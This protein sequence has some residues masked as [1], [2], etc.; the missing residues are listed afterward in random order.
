MGARLEGRIALVTGA[1][2]GIG[3]A[4][5]RLLAAEGARV[6]ATDIEPAG[7]AETAEGLDDA[8][9]TRRLD[10]TSEAE[11]RSAVD[12]TTAEF[13]GLHVLLNNAGIAPK[14]T[15][16]Q[17]SLEGW[18][19]IHGICL[20]GVYLGCHAALPAM[21]ASG[22]GSIVNISSVAALRGVAVYAAYCS[23]KAGVHMLTKTIALHCGR[24][25]YNIRANSVHPGPID[26]PI[27][28][29]DRERFGRRAIDA[30]AEAIPLGR[31][32]RPEEVAHCVLFLASEESSF[33]NGT[34]LVVDGGYCAK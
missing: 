1:G 31:I 17:E 3:R 24:R 12:A 9:L 34:E 18:R 23:A 27:L 21:A 19:R 10:V 16:E 25:G 13:G 11:W 33:V 5:A 26:T 7:L 6:M 2:S 4:S 22:G 20:D 15:I 14:A 32:G 30:R 29:P 8:M 28:D